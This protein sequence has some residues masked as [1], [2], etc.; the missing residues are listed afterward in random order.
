MFILSKQA[1]TAFPSEGNQTQTPRLLHPLKFEFNENESKETPRLVVCDAKALTKGKAGQ[2]RPTSSRILNDTLFSSL[3][4][5]ILL[6][7]G[8]IEHLFI[9]NHHTVHN[10]HLTTSKLEPLF[11][12]SI[13]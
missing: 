8:G 9:E 4:N 7:V 1:S 6:R 11:Y 12:H 5:G 13:C 10:R 3:D 2:A